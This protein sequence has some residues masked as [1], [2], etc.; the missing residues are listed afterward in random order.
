M[1][2][3]VYGTLRDPD[4]RLAV[5]GHRLAPDQFEAATA[6]GCRVVVFPGRSYPG[7]SPSADASAEGVVISGL[8]PGDLLLLDAFEGNE[9]RRR[10]I[11]LIVNGRP[12]TAD[13]YWPVLPIPA[14]A[15]NWRLD[16]WVA[17]HK[18]AFLAA[19][20]GTTAN[21]ANASPRPRP[22]S[23]GRRTANGGES[24]MPHRRTV[25]LGLAVHEPAA[26]RRRHRPAF[27]AGTPVEPD[28]I[29]TAAGDL[30]IQPVNHASIVLTFGSDIIY[31]DP[32]GGGPR[33]QAFNKPTAIVI[34]HAHPDHFD[35]TTLTAIAGSAKLIIGP[36]AVIDGLPPELKAKAKLMKNGDSGDINGIPVSAIA[37]YNTTADRLKYHPKGEGNGYV[38]T[39]G[40]A[41][42]YV[43]GDT[44]DTP[45]MRALTG[46][47]R[48]LHPD[49]PALHHD[50][51]R[52]RRGGEAF[53]PQDRLPLPL[54]QGQR[55]AAK[56]AA[57]LKSVQR[58]RG[59][60]ARLVRVSLRG[61][62]I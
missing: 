20:A 9:Y 23:A 11:E 19:E 24:F 21:C 8:T 37:A 47:R 1:P 13:V 18:A 29:T 5:L 50:R 34:T 17:G 61:F 7:L 51:R 62:S 59:P 41:K 38:F 49:E 39:F 12:A 42:V 56:F 15:A 40:A 52:R 4:V 30:I 57:A 46:H 35:V 45:E 2:L 26:A 28:T 55:R 54:R 60:P 43:A 32:V 25:L 14:T 6:P 16:D 22:T 48:G 3:F 27:A 44:E 10:A 36:Q 31:V 58:H 53:Q 33:Y